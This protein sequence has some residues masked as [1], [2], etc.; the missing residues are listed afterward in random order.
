MLICKSLNRP[1]AAE[2]LLSAFNFTCPKGKGGG[3]NRSDN[4]GP[5]SQQALF[6]MG[7]QSRVLAYIQQQTR[8][9]NA[10]KGKSKNTLHIIYNRTLFIQLDNSDSIDRQTFLYPS[11]IKRHYEGGKRNGR[12]VVLNR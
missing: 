9:S 5:G 7:R 8:Y 1:L 3:E 2:W 11:F 6:N 12:F 4:L 10:P